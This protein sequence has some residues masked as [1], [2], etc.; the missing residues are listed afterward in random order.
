MSEEQPEPIHSLNSFASPTPVLTDGKLIGHFGTNGTAC[1]DTRSGRVLWTNR[2]L[3]IKHENGAGSSPILWRDRVIFHC[4]G[5]DQQYIVALDLQTGAVVWKTD[6][7]GTMHD[8]PQMKK[9]YGTPLIVQID[10]QPVVI[11]PAADW[12]YG[13]DPETGREL[14]KV[15]YGDLGFSIVPRPVAGHG[16]VFMSTSFMQPE[17]LGVKL[18]GQQPSIVWRNKRQMP[19]QPSPLLIGEQIYV[20]SDK[21]IFSSLNA[22]TGET[23]YAERLGG[24]FSSSPLYAAGRIYLSNREGST[25]VL[26]PGPEFKVLA[27]NLLPGQIMASPVAL[28]KT[29]YLRTDQALYAIE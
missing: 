14:W 21:G 27:T 25:Y 17:L 19:S 20:V 13:Y 16:M 23:I 8:H 29:L 4:D 18:G 1:L 9:A 2:D 24:N 22:L 10:G 15:A 12:L 26:Q 6:R 11:S 7:T 28:G 5:S 3:R